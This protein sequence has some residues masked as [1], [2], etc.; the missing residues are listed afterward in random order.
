MR[1]DRDVVLGVVND[2]LT[3]RGTVTAVRHIS[4]GLAVRVTGRTN[5]IRASHALRE[6]GFPA[7]L[8]DAHGTLHIP[9]E[10]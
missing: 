4:G 7:E 8:D 9:G 5:R 10:R 2:A 3:V 6:A 1:V